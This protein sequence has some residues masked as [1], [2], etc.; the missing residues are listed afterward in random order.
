MCGDRAEVAEA[1]ED[2]RSER[3]RVRGELAIVRVAEIERR[4]RPVRLRE[5]PQD[6]AVR[7]AQ[8]G[9]QERSELGERDRSRMQPR[10]D[11]RGD[12]RMGQHGVLEAVGEREPARVQEIRGASDRRPRLHACRPARDAD[13][14][15]AALPVAAVCDLGAE[16]AQPDARELRV[17]R[18]Q[19]PPHRLLERIHRAAAGRLP[20]QHLPAESD[21]GR[22]DRASR[23]LSVDL[24]RV[25][26]VRHR[27][28]RAAVVAGGA[29]HEQ[30]E[31][32]FGVLE[33]E[34][35][36][37]ELLDLAR[38]LP[39]HGAVCVQLHAELARALDDVVATAQLADE[40][41]PRVADDGRVDVLV[42]RRVERHRL[43]VDAA[44]VGKG[45]GAHEGQPRVRRKVRHRVDLGRERRQVVQM[46][47]RR[48]P[49]AHLQD[50][51][52]ERRSTGWRSRSA[53]RTR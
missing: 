14:H 29:A 13:S 4:L 51:I 35:L 16:V 1:V 46:L 31:G 11:G 22:R 17:G 44:L 48:A 53:R 38:D 49:E 2:R 52:R 21:L 19:C 34:A 18:E 28:E 20:A 6:G 24:A 12:S 43:H 41:V 25:H 27:L 26:R 36:A 30:L 50:E 15:R 3:G 39:R 10:L 7:L 47:E 9:S 5:R 32:G 45:G 33:L 37:L 42:R 23:L 40:D 8:L